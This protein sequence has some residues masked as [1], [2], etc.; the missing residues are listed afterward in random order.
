MLSPLEFGPLAWW[1]AS[2]ASTFT[3]SSGSVVS[4]W[5]D[6]SGNGNHLTQGTVANQPGR[7]GTQNG[8]STV[9][10]DG[11]NDLMVCST[12]DTATSGATNLTIIAAYLRP[13][14]ANGAL[15]G[16]QTSSSTKG[17]M[18][19]HPSGSSLTTRIANATNTANRTYS[20]LTG[21]FRIHT[22]VINAAGATEVPTQRSN[23]V[24]NGT[25]EVDTGGFATAAGGFAV[26]GRASG[27]G[28]PAD[29]AVG[30][31]VI[32]NSIVALDTIGRIEAY[33]NAQWAAY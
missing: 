18:I 5:N 24:E 10:F 17:I 2:D 23:G 13:T 21:T 12:L 27:G 31:L 20:S 15:L 28:L 3:F 9:V 19:F 30:G 25:A 16:T 8:L 7:T 1:D 4:Q 14:I 32:F 33:M 26:G 22:S 11:S 6:K 29:M